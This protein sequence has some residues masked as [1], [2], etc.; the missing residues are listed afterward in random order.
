MVFQNKRTQYL[1]LPVFLFLSA[2][3][4][5]FF[6][7]IPAYA[8]TIYD[9]PYVSF[10]PDKQAF[11]TNAWDRSVQWYK[12]GTIVQI[13]G[14]LKRS[15]EAGEHSYR[16][17]CTGA[18]P[19][20]YW[21]V[22]YEGARCIHGAYPPMGVDYHGISFGRKKCLSNHYSGW[23]AYCAVCGEKIS[24][25]FFY[26]S[27]EAAASISELDLSKD[28]YYL[29][30]FCSNLEMGANLGTHFCDGISWNRYQVRYDKNTGDWVEGSMANSVH[31]YQNADIYEGQVISAE[32]SLRKNAY[33]RAGYAFAGWNTR[34]D[35]SGQSYQDGQE[36]LNLTEENYDQGGKGI[37]VMY[38]QWVEIESTL[39]IDPAGGLYQGSMDIY[40][41][42]L[43]YGDSYTLDMN[44]LKAPD[45]NKIVFETNG[46]SH[47]EPAKGRTIF[48]EW[49]KK[50][51]FQG[52]FYDNT[53]YSTVAEGAV[54]TIVAS[55]RKEP[56]FLPATEKE[57]Y[58]FQGWYLDPECT[59]FA[60]KEGDPFIPER[61]VTLYASWTPDFIL[62]ASLERILEPA[63]PVFRCG[64][65]GKLHFMVSGYAEKVTVSFPE[66]LREG[67]TGLNFSFQYNG[68]ELSHEEDIIFMVPLYTPKGK[69]SVTVTAFKG[70]DILSETPFLWTLGEEE[71]VLND[72]RTR[73][74]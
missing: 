50:S 14:S 42:K 55:Y 6:I 17:Q 72:I 20:G 36:I 26:M 48:Q 64:E 59:L 53:Y 73:L 60:G 24:N 44:C 31:M 9:S 65:S 35:G 13:R 61:D 4:C 37:V 18:V 56:V 3:I 10:S 32:R 30:P 2:L 41:V 69:Y 15:P 23:M 16:M 40:P 39:Q 1:F 27:Q 57:D 66:E 52:S 34:P 45:G 46:G 74:R 5:W 70:A 33:K 51:P 28:Y 63:D 19:V 54:D 62:R 43:K 8:D 71:S 68:D 7:F 25:T 11:T 49:V 12:S 29:C 38:A 22:E 47:V 21:K 67:I 58:S